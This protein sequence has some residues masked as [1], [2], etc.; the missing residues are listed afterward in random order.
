MHDRLLGNRSARKRFASARAGAR[1]DAARDRRRARPRRLRDAAVH[2]PLRRGAL[3]GDRGAGRGV[4]RRDGADDRRGRERQGAGGQGVRRPGTASRASRSPRTTRGSRPSRRGACSTSRTPTSGS[5]RSSRTS[6]SGTRRSSPRRD[7]R[8]AS[9]NWH[10]DFDDKHLLKAFV[11]LSDVGAEH[12]P[13]EYVPAASPAAATTSVRPGCRW[14]TAAST[15]RT[16]RRA[17]RPRRS[18]P[19][20]GPKGTLILCNTS[21]LH[22]GGFA[23][24]GPRVLAT[25]TYCSPASLKALS[26]RNYDD[27]ARG[28]RD[29]PGRPLRRLVGARLDELGRP[30]EQRPH[31]AAELTREEPFAESPSPGRGRGSGRASAR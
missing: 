12:G 13:F 5:G 29:R 11:Y 2:R 14:A 4:R 27:A 25:A 22:R 16:W 30:V 8:V 10:V 19:S 9:Q 28:R 26:N 3:A 23:T 7:E 31:A 15:T 17:S 21:G 6:T 24:A 18:R 1:R 20:R